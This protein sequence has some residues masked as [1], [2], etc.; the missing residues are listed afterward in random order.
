MLGPKSQVHPCA[1][2]L[3]S[4]LFQAW[5]DSD[6]NAHEFS[7]LIWF[8]SWGSVGPDGP[9]YICR[10]HL[11]TNYWIRF[12]FFP[13]VVGFHIFVLPPSLLY[14]P[15]SLLY[16]PPTWADVFDERSRCPTTTC[17]DDFHRRPFR[18]REVTNNTTRHSS[19]VINLV[20]RTF[21]TFSP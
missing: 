20:F 17:N 3:L 9:E 12:S 4:T 6:N 5:Q 7:T 14:L 15:P 8:Y 16:L 1:H 21:F 19:L 18:C 2:T 13:A 10:E 11:R